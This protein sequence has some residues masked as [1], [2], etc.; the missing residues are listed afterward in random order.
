MG[1][2]MMTGSGILRPDELDWITDRIAVGGMLFDKEDMNRLAAVGVTHILNLNGADDTH[3]AAPLG[4]VTCWN[5]VDDDLKPKPPEFFE[6]SVKFAKSA[7]RQRGSK[8]YIHCAAGIHRAPMTALAVLCS[9]GWGVLDAMRHMRVCRPCVN[10]PE[11]YVNSVLR[12]LKGAGHEGAHQG[13]RRAAK[14]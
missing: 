1:G 8:L 13:T 12:Y 14:A 2:A 3:L 10:F 7:M 11:V 4:I 6:R 5:H 9:M